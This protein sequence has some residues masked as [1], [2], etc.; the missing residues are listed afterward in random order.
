MKRL[1]IIFGFCLAASAA[2]AA[3]DDARLLAAIRQVE[4]GGNDRAVGDG[5]RSRGPYQIGRA[6]W[7]DACR[8]GRVKW[9]YDKYVWDPARSAQ[10]MRWYW[11]RYHARTDERKARIHNGGPAGCRKPS[12]IDYWRRVRKAARK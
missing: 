7:T 5:G 10:V 12:T 6:Y 9:S 8:H 3:T 4:S 1:S 2:S 11:D